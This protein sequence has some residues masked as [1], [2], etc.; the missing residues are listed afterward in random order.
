MGEGLL[1]RYFLANTMNA[2][3]SRIVRRSLRLVLRGLALAAV[4]V[5]LLAQ[6][7]ADER[8]ASEGQGLKPI[9]SYISGAWDTLTRSM[10][11]CG[12]LADPKIKAAPVLYLPSGMATPEAVR[13]LSRECNVQIEHLPVVIHRLGE[14]D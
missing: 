4:A 12:S 5:G 11:D 13:K 7:P 6:T 2:C 10:T 9:L 1:M 3:I 14:I 8:T